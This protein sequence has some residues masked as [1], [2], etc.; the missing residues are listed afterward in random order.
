MTYN[1]KW[2]YA[3]MEW[4]L[5]YTDQLK[6]TSI[7]ALCLPNACLIRNFTSIRAIFICTS[8][9]DTLHTWGSTLPLH[10][11]LQTPFWGANLTPLQISWNKE[12]TS[13]CVSLEWVFGDIIEYFKFLDFWKNLKIKLSVVIKMHIVCA[14]LHNARSC[15]YGTSTENYFGLQPTLIGEHFLC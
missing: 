11:P 8:W 2:L 15:F 6:G 10:S 7:T 13:A 5:I 9:G 14:L 3:P 4:W 1:F 12:I